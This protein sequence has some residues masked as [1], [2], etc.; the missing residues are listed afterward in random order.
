MAFCPEGRGVYRRIFN[1][2]IRSDNCRIILRSV[3]LL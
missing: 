2:I 3:D 1:Q